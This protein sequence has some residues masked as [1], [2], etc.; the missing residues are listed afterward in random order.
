M[1]RTN[2][3]SAELHP[4]DTDV[5]KISRRFRR[6]KIGELR[7]EPLAEGDGVVGE[8]NWPNP[9]SGLARARLRAFESLP[10]QRDSINGCARG[11]SRPTSRFPPGSNQYTTH[12]V[13]PPQIQKLDDAGARR[14]PIAVKGVSER[15][16]EEHFTRERR[17]CV[18]SG[19]RSSQQASRSPVHLRRRDRASSG[20]A[21]GE[22]KS[23]WMRA[24]AGISLLEA[25]GG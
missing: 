13:Q 19:E 25:L 8:R 11:R 14:R 23:E 6:K 10:N 2:R 21:G 20:L 18:R 5:N 9:S 17:G 16:E 7:G 3:L 1:P 12:P 15:S 4:L 22:D 24:R